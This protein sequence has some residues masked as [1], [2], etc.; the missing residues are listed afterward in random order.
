MLPRAVFSELTSNK[1]YQS[2]ADI[3]SQSDFIE[4]RDVRNTQALT[5][6]QALTPL[7]LGESEAIILAQEHDADVLLMDEAKGRKIAQQLHI[8]LSGALG[9]L[10]D[11]FD[12]GLLAK[13]EVSE[14][15]DVL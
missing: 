14:C 3:I 13:S 6:L 15:L 2:E 1:T 12:S 4:C 10:I 9:I 7:D 11:C 8:P 5:V